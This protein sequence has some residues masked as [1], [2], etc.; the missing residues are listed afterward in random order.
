MSKKRIYMFIN[1]NSNDDVCD[2]ARLLAYGL[3]ESGDI[4]AVIEVE[5][6]IVVNWAEAKKVIN[7]V[8]DEYIKNKAQIM[9][10]IRIAVRDNSNFWLINDSDFLIDCFALSQAS[11][12]YNDEL[13]QIQTR[14]ELLSC[15]D[16][17]SHIVIL[18]VAV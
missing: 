16:N 3:I 10:D 15:I 17:Y 13:D 4:N 18:S 6:A 8:W 11:D 2:D 5:K 1:Q 7:E 12:F 14:E 9:R